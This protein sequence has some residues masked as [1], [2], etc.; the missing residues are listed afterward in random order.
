MGTTSAPGTSLP[1]SPCPGTQGWARAISTQF[2][3]MKNN[4]FYSLSAYTS[5]TLCYALGIQAE[6]NRCEFLPSG[7]LQ[8]MG[9]RGIK[10]LIS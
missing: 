4:T 3:A 10:Q 5:Q 9:E 6:Q 7:N 2:N 8:S 1:A